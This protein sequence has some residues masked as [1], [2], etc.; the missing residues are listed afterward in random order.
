MTM[1]EL[2]YQIY[3]YKLQIIIC[4]KLKSWRVKITNNVALWFWTDLFSYYF[5]N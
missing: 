1:T 2:I 5:P 3:Q 4:I